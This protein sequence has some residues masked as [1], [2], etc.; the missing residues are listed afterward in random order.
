MYYVEY[1]K[2]DITISSD[3]DIY[4]GRPVSLRLLRLIL[5]SA[6]VTEQEMCICIIRQR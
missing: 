5:N 1:H 6:M 3:D 2:T 4:D